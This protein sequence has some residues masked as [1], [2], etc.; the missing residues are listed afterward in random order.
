VLTVPIILGIITELFYWPSRNYPFEFDDIPNILKFYKIRSASFTELFFSGPRWISYWLNTVLYKFSGFEPNLYRQLNIIFHIISGVLVFSLIYKLLNLL[1]QKTPR[2]LFL[3][4]YNL[5]IST[6][7]SALFLLHP[8]QT[9]TITYVIQGQLEGLATLFILL[10]LNLFVL[11][12]TTTKKLVYISSTIALFLTALLATG[13][14]EIIIVT[15]ILIFL[16][17]WFFVTQGNFKIIKQRKFLYFII[18][19]LILGAY[20]YFLKPTFFKNILLFNTSHVNTIGNIITSHGTG[21]I[22]PYLYLISEF[23]VILHYLYIFIWPFNLSFEYDWKIVPSFFDWASFGPF[24]ILLLLVIYLIWR[25]RKNRTDLIAFGL[26]WFFVAILPRSSIIPSPELINDY[27]TYL[28]ALGILLILALGL[29]KLLVWLIS[30]LKIKSHS[31][32]KINYQLVIYSGTILIFTL[33]LGTLTYQRNLVS[34]TA[35]N[36]WADVI[37]KAPQK[38]RAHNNYGIAL[39]K[40]HDYQAAI[41][42][43]KR[44]IQIEGK[45]A[46][47]AQF[48]WDPYNN[49]ANLYALTGRVP[50]AVELLEHGLKFNNTVAEPYNNLGMFYINLHKFDQAE[51]NLRRSLAIKPYHGKALFNLAK[52]YVLREQFPQALKLLQQACFDSDLDTEPQ[53]RISALELY[54]SVALHIR[55]TSNLK[56]V[57]EALLQ[58]KPNDQQVLFNLA[59]TYANQKEYPKAIKIYQRLIKQDPTNQRYLA[60]LKELYRLNNQAL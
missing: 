50:E 38:A 52:V 24:L 33:I 45:P 60:N 7:T 37:K 27:K 39:T 30:K 29:T 12:V 9:Q 49:L 58:H 35:I 41:I 34:E 23:R 42:E 2:N 3:N 57:F 14:K 26:L 56:P 16:I 54:A 32:Q 13:A 6:L 18:T 10:I 17:D 59:G 5:I 11:S 44:A 22:T 28:A 25:L 4:K 20:L 48:Y 21:E 40:A 1:S 51:L 36:Y 55:D 47:I 8:V 31:K 43:F 19:S 53:A 46:T 15:P